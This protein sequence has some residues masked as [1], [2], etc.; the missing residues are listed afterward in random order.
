MSATAAN[1]PPLTEVDWQLVAGASVVLVGAGAVGRPLIR[2]LA[3]LGLR[4]A[5]IVDPKRYRE[6]SVHSQCRPEEV[7]RLKAEVVAEE[8][9]ALG[10]QAVALPRD[11]EHVPPGYFENSLVIVSVDNRRAEILT[12]RQAGRMRR[13]LLKANIEP[14]FLTA[15]L[16]FYDFSHAPTEVCLE[17]QMSDAHYADQHHP[18]SCDGEGA[19]RPTASPR[20]LCELAANAGA[21]IAA[22]ILGSPHYWANNWRNRQ[23]QANLLGGQSQVSGLPPKLNCRWDHSACWNNLIRFDRPLD[24]LT[25]AELI[26]ATGMAVERA[27]I[28]LSTQAT[29]RVRCNACGA[30]QRL[31]RTICRL[32]DELGR[33]DCGGALC[34]TPFYCFDHL[35]AD[36]LAPWLDW[37]LSMCGVERL[38][39][40]SVADDNRESSFLL[41]A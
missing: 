8:L 30:S 9:L 27:Y 20:P 31:L 34:A 18:L 26:F 37:P 35:A 41:T 23:W 32:D 15:S 19:A 40:V 4:R 14:L 13:P 25:L 1:L 33:C 17:C 29:T 16:R 28:K 22:Q 6:R 39:V 36:D 11:I 10:V 2:G 38:S 24:Q 12:N 21:L 7:G 3:Q 5:V